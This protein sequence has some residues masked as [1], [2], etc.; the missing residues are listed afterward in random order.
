MAKYLSDQFDNYIVHLGDDFDKKNGTYDREQYFY[1]LLDETNKKTLAG[2]FKAYPK[3][4]E[5]F[6][7]KLRQPVAKTFKDAIKRMPL[8]TLTGEKTS[9]FKTYSKKRKKENAD[10]FEAHKRLKYHYSNDPHSI[11]KQTHIY[12]NKPS[13]G[14]Y[15][16]H[17]TIRWR[18][19]KFNYNFLKYGYDRFGKK[20]E[21]MVAD[22]TKDYEASYD[23]L[24]KTLNGKLLYSGLP[25]WGSVQRM[26][27]EIAEQLAK[28]MFTPGKKYT[29][30]QLA[31]K[32][33]SNQMIVDIS[34]A[35]Y[36]DL[37]HHDYTG[38]EY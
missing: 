15:K 38:G 6:Y 22:W 20:H 37:E 27:G 12:L 11:R 31:S 1:N 26:A 16:G 10:Y 17:I 4:K 14:A 32:A 36:L 9:Q 28:D 7:K 2:L 23:E 35:F 21:E 30:S 25:S 13:R 29:K 24:A 3:F 34:S 5:E 33:R 8:N 19:S 18:V